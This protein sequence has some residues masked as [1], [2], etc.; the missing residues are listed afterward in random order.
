MSAEKVDLYLVKIRHDRIDST[1]MVEK[2]ENMSLSGKSYI[3]YGK[4]IAKDKL[5]KL[6]TS[7]YR[8][9][10]QARFFTYAL[11]ADVPRA[12]EQLKAKALEEL[13]L[14]KAEFDN[15]YSRKGDIEII[16]PVYRDYL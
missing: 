5:M 9:H 6:D 11:L 2:M 15:V 1:I 4:R 12:I 8:S 16:Q 3:G 14:V 7:I 13:E 10:T